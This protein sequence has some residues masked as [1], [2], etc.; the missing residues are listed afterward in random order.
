M[1]FLAVDLVAKSHVWQLPPAGER[2]IRDGA[3][4][5]WEVRFVRALTVSDGDGNEAFSDEACAAVADAEVY[6]GFG[7]PRG[8][9]GAAR[10]LR[11]VH[12]ASAGV[13]AILYPEMRESQVILT[14]SAGVHAVP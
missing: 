10:A 11:W 6:A 12:S 4:P 14:N 7:M 3:P 13:G 1:P 5:G 2:A 8:L 9:F